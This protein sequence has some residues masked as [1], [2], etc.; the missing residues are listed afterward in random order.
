M[1]HARR[2]A[3]FGAGYIGLVTGACLAELGHTVAVRDILPERVELLQAGEVPIY[4]PGLGD[5]TLRN[6]ERLRFTLDAEDA[7]RGAEVAYVCVDTPPTASEDADLSRVWA[8]VDA[9][10]GASHL[11]AL[12]V[13]STVPVGTGRRIRAALDAA[14]L[15]HVGYVSNPEFT[16]EG[17]AVSDFMNP[18]RIVIGASDP[19]AADLIKGLHAGVN[20][21]AVVMDV[22]S[23]EMTK[24]AANAALATK[25]TL[26]NEL[27]TVCEATGA[28]IERVTEAIGM[29]HR[30]GPHFLKAG[31]GYG[32]S[33]FP[34][35]SRA[36][37]ALASNAGYSFQ[38][39]R[40]VIEVNGLQARRHLQRLKEELGGSF[41]G[42]S[43]ALLGMT[44]KAGTDDMRE[45]PST[46]IASRLLAE[47]AEV[48]CW[49]PMA[50]P[51][52]GQPWDSTTRQAG[53][54][55][56]MAGAD[57]AVIVTEWPELRDAPWAEAHTAMRTPLLLDGRNLL[58]GAAMAQ[59]GFTYMSVGR[60]TVR[61]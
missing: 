47:G 29:D 2:V 5:M 27:A 51:G 53:P 15:G 37:H 16:A 35:D 13:K 33:C 18:D 6:K 7:V 30:I 23:A 57:A 4:E 32:G 38:L 19:A 54:L 52:P 46:I 41:E 26:A 28:D 36:L 12:V 34:K 45:A 61:P 17:R 48:R 10:K 40:T 3:V 24:L 39:L 58:D 59:L 25:I 31:L 22:A 8:V 60:P 55:E 21:P 9:L 43:V 20:G 49:D 14:G 44:F 42:R 1:E 50:Q 56:A 11:L